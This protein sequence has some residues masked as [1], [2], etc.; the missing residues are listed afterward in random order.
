V[1]RRGQLGRDILRF[2]GAACFLAFVLIAPARADGF[3]EYEKGRFDKAEEAFRRQAEDT[4]KAQPGYNLGNAL[5]RQGRFEESSKAYSEA[6]AKDPNLQAGWY[7]LG[8][9]LYRQDRFQDAVEVYQRALSLRSDDEDAKFNLELARQQLKKDPKKDKS[10]KKEEPT[11]TPN[12]GDQGNEDKKGQGQD[13]KDKPDP[14]GDQ[15]TG[16]NDQQQQQQQRQEEEERQK[17][18]Q[19][20]QQRQDQ[21][22]KELGMS[23]QQV[24]EKLDQLSRQE[25]QLQAYF[26]RDPHRRQRPDDPFKNAPPYQ[27]ALLKHFFGDRFGQNQDADAP[28]KDW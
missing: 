23:D 9:A 12:K 4:S 18:S 21:A 13:P 10:Q 15:K 19:R 28:D 2:V 26:N 5:Y 25:K 17:A 24:K 3:K 1:V 11:P 7:T 8:N 16:K 14:K 6:L 27:R 20:R 22:R